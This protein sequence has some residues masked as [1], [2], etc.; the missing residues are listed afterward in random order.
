M[1]EEPRLEAYGTVVVFEDRYG[2]RWD[3]IQ[4]V[5]DHGGWRRD[6]VQFY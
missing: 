2:N 6:V 4:P 3:L 1:T 5:G